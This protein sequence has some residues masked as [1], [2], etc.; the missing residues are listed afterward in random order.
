MLSTEPTTSARLR[1][2]G[3]PRDQSITHPLGWSN[4]CAAGLLIWVLGSK[5]RASSLLVSTSPTELCLELL[6]RG[7]YPH[8]SFS[9]SVNALSAHRQYFSVWNVKIKPGRRS[10]AA[11][12]LLGAQRPILPWWCQYILV[13]L[14]FSQIPGSPEAPWCLVSSQVLHSFLSL[15]VI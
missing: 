5:P 12:K 3:S 6:E 9:H 14:L 1:S 10:Q 11:R 13:A 7:L 2:S 4:K 15:G 8:C